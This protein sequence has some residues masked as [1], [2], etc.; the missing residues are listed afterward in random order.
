[1]TL[2]VR[3]YH[4]LRR[5]SNLLVVGSEAVSDI[6]V[7]PLR[8][9]KV[10]IEKARDEHCGW[11]TVQNW[12]EIIVIFVYFYGRLWLEGVGVN[13]HLKYIQA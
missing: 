3:S 2:N 10:L 4:K 11:N 7:L 9:L 6:I 1:M 5:A 13:P 12:G 8:S